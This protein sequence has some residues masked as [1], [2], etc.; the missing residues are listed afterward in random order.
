MSLVSVVIGTYNGSKFIEAQLQSII[1]QTYSN[2]EIII[3]DD[4]SQD[5]TVEIVQTIADKHSNINIHAFNE[6]LGYIKNFE[7]G[8]ALAK[9]DFIAL[10]DQDDWWLD[11]K[12]EKLVSNI[13]NHDIIYCDSAFTDENLKPNGDSFSKGKH[14]LNSN[15]PL[16]FLIENCASGHAMLLKK[17]L[18][19]K[20]IPFPKTIPHDWWLTYNATLNNGIYYFD[21]ALVHYRHHDNNV[22][23]ENKTKK[24][25]QTK[26]TERR[27]RLKAF[28]IAAHQNNHPLANT[29]YQFHKSYTSFA[30][31]NNIKRVVLFS[32][33]KNDILAI[34]KKSSFK[35]SI[36][37]INMFFKLK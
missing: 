5:N 19:D 37:C 22:I 31:T 18:F 27:E 16:H 14:M 10:S 36:F 25:S 35:K 6:N 3:A 29:I 23:A 9:G 13:G 33:H 15:N 32:K 24:S 1:H 20:T 7:R 17:S 2:I 26:Q 28:Y 21:D 4:A 30:L 11:T 12:I 34:L 8:M